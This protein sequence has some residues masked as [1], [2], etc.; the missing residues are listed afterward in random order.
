MN[1]VEHNIRLSIKEL[2]GHFMTSIFLGRQTDL[3][4]AKHF[5]LCTKYRKL[6]IS[7]AEH[8]IVEKEVLMSGIV[9]EDIACRK[10]WLCPTFHE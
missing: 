9:N 8:S 1:N 10:K 3:L 5:I 2:L 7:K 6:P 4:Y